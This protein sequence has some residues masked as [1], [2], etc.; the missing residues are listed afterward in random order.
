MS[1]PDKHA[2]ILAQTRLLPVPH[3]PEISLHI[4]DV[5]TE[6]WSKTEEELGEIERTAAVP[7]L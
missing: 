7:A 2:F 4:A 5:A 1:I 6:L 3:A